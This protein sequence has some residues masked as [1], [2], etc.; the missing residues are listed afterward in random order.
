[1]NEDIHTRLSSGSEPCNI[2]Q[3]NMTVYSHAGRPSVLLS[4][5]KINDS[6]SQKKP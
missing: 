5:L 3:L 2:C 6:F 4:K 1:M